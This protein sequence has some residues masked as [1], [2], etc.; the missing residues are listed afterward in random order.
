MKFVRHTQCTD[1][2]SIFK[3]TPP[4]H[5][6]TR[7]SSKT[8]QTLIIE[9]PTTPPICSVIFV[10]RVTF[11][12]TPRVD[13][14][15]TM[16]RRSCCYSSW[17][18]SLLLALISF[19]HTTTAFLFN[20]QVHPALESISYVE[21]GTAFRTRLDFDYNDGRG[22]SHQLA[23]S[24]PTIELLNDPQKLAI[25]LPNADIGQS[26]LS[27]GS[28]GVKVLQEAFFVGM[29]SKKNFKEQGDLREESPRYATLTVCLWC[30]S[31]MQKVP[32]EKGCKLWTLLLVSV[33]ECLCRSA[34]H[35]LQWLCHRLGN[36]LDGR[37][38]RRSTQ[39]CL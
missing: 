1:Q 25:P 4:H 23:I 20:A 17:I 13:W 30:V 5:I 18:S 27:T 16:M 33:V 39:L 28:K 19:G 37:A 7:N 26:H 14:L 32:F 11:S 29:Q 3:Q 38:A 6:R 15:M 12:W 10:C 2:L 22:K 24:G 8:H 21:Q 34:T 35:L 9:R 31:G 36:G